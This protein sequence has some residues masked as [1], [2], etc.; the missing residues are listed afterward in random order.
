M[1][2]IELNIARFPSILLLVYSIY[3]TYALVY[4]MHIDMKLPVW[5]SKRGKNTHL[6]CK[7]K[8]EPEER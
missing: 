7:E 4:Y 5:Q 3:S 1:K 6:K 2:N 8:N